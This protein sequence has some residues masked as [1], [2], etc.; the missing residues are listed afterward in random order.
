MRISG[1]AVAAGVAVTIAGALTTAVPVAAAPAP[2]MRRACPATRSDTPRCLTLYA[3]QTAVN[4]AIAEKAAGK[5][6]PVTSTTPKGWGATSIEAAYKLPVTRGASQTVAIVDAFST[7]H[8]ASDLAFY[9]KHYGLP[10]CATATGCL[11]IVN[12]L[13]KASPLPRPDPAG[14]GVE[15]TL[16]VAM[17]SAACPLCKIIMVEGARPTFGALAAAEDTAVRLGAQVVSNSYGGRENGFTQAEAKHYVHPGHVIV[18]ASGDVGFTAAQFPAN[19]A[20]VTDAGGTTLAKATNARGW[21][22]TVWNDGG[23]ASGSG[24]SAYVAKPAWQHDPHC[25]GRTSADVA[26]VATNIAIYD[27]SLPKGF[28]GPWFTIEGTSA[29]APLIAGVYGL[30]GNAATVQPG[31]EYAH[32]NALFD[33]TQGNNDWFS[34]AGGASCGHDY[35]CVAKKGYDAPT[36]LGSPDG[37]GAF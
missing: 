2:A 31:F 4:R 33:V 21:S 22:E 14:W 7:P 36:G 19:L 6:V 32:A 28:G 1:I 27:T 20:N 3:P 25:P 9:R 8:L 5:P 13:G 37:I 15:E 26:A 34:G 10:P 16:D 12:Q 24:C 18:A 35:L 29:S 11:K 23:G 30:A 17:V